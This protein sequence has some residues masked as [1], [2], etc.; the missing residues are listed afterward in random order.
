MPLDVTTSDGTSW[1]CVEAYAGLATSTPDADKAKAVSAGG[2]QVDVIA[3]PS[4]GAQTVRLKLPANW[5]TAVSEAEL[6][7]AIKAAQG[8]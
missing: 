4:G 2:G 7:K 8:A 3:T 6:S 1:N 5:E